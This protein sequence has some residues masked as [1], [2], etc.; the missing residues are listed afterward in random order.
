MLTNQN[1]IT[2]LNMGFSQVTNHTLPVEHA[3]KVVKMRKALSEDY[4]KFA[5]D[6]E[7]LRKDAGIENAVELD[8][9]L[10]ELRK[11]EKRTKEQEKRLKEMEDMLKRYHEMRNELLKSEAKLEGVKAMP[12]DAWHLLQKENAEKVIGGKAVDLLP[13]FVEDMLEGILWNAPEE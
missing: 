6:E 12:Y 11:N 10:D 9:E 4:E 1:V 7:A 3:Y 8:K 5:K 2:L 13:G